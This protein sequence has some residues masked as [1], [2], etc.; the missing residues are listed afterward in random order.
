MGEIG[1]ETGHRSR[2]VD[3]PHTDSRRSQ[4]ATPY[5]PHVHSD[6]WQNATFPWVE[7]RNRNGSGAATPLS[8]YLPA[9]VGMQP[10][11]GRACFQ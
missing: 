6:S 8:S 11:L 1:S 7:P 5:L 4:A 9:G 2:R 10:S 3:Q